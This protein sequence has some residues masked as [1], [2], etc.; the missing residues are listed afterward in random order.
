LF[1]MGDSEQHRRSEH[2]D[3]ESGLSRSE[4]LGDARLEVAAAERVRAARTF[5]PTGVVAP[6]VSWCETGYPIGWRAVRYEQ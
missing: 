6:V 3:H 4:Q 2:A 5:G 1:G